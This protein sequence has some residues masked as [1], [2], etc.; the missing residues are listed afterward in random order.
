MT[1]DSIRKKGKG[2][3]YLCFVLLAVRIATRWNQTGQKFASEP[4]IVNT[5][6]LK[7]TTTL[8]ALVFIA[9]LWNFQNMKSQ[10]SPY[11]LPYLF[12]IMT[13][14][15][16]TAALTFKLAITG[17]NSPEVVGKTLRTI[18]NFAD[19]KIPVVFRARFF[20]ILW[21]TI[22]LLVILSRSNHNKTSFRKFLPCGL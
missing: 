6:L 1:L 11:S 15:L 16:S 18:I 20:F 13:F 21:T 9:Y 2:V 10:K 7:H 12:E 3:N 14:I 4:D 17:E 22:L 8:W 19:F 5:F